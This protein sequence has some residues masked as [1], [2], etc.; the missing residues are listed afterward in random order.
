MPLNLPGP[1]SGVTGPLRD[2][3]EMLRGALNAQ[4]SWSYAS[5]A[6]P[7]S[8][9]TGKKG[10]FF[11]NTGSASTLSRLWHKTGPD[12][13]TVSTTSWAVVRILA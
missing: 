12:N 2:Y 5:V 6:N 7:N 3:L 8:V 13:N 11:L 1:P 4:P 9:V 10:D